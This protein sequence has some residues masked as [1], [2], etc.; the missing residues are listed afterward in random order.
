MKIMKIDM[1]NT[2]FMTTNTRE[3]VSPNPLKFDYSHDINFLPKGG[4]Y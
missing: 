1:R 4:D 2:Y 3:E